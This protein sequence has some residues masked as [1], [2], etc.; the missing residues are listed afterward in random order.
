MKQFKRI[1]ILMT[2]MVVAAGITTAKGA[3]IEKPAVLQEALLSLTI[4]DFHG[5]LDGLGST[6][7]QVSPMMNATTLKSL[8]GMQLGD[9]ELAGI[10]AGKGLAVVALDPKTI[11]GVIELSAAQLAP[12]TNKLAAT[13][14]QSHYTKGLLVVGKTA[15]AVQKGI[16]AAPRVRATLLAHRTPTLRIAMQPAGYITAN[17][18]KIDGM[19]QMMPAMMGQSMQAQAKAQG[20]SPEAMQGITRLLEGELRVL[21]SI[22]KQVQAMEITLAPGGGSLRIDK[23]LEPVAGSRLAALVSAPRQNQWNPKI[24]SGA[25]GSA[26]FMLDFLIE[27]SDALSAFV[28]AETASLVSQMKLEGAEVKR[29]SEYMQKCMGICGGTVSESI[30][31]GTTPGLSL[32]YIMEVSD[33][34]AA[35]ALLRNMQAE[36]KATGFMD[37][38]ADMGMPMSFEFKENT[39]QYKGVGIHRLTTKISMEQMPEMQR[40]QF[41]AMNLSN[42]KYEVAILDGIMAYTMGD[43]RM[44]SVIDGIRNPK[45]GIAPLRA[46]TVFPAGGFYYGDIDMGRYMEFVSSFMPA[47]PA[48]PMPL[49]M[50]SKLLKGAEPITS[51]GHKSGG[52]VQWSMNMP[53]DLLARIGQAAMAIQMQKMQQMNAPAPV[54]TQP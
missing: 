32:D 23:V 27:N 44:E 43:T 19:M 30:F 18:E 5:M 52:L 11:F 35:L 25:A 47:M 38:Y 31:G 2:A 36:L 9:P 33:E 13:G 6:A 54:T 8:L 28:A 53:A 24:Q 21:L 14:M 12:Y 26:A 4:S 1:S 46:R 10:A 51:A 34:K 50:I 45:A 16:A 42:M 37:L 39:R 40:Q 3:Q 20:Q 17:S 49:E 7:S 15:A 22:M 29:I 48:T 41:E